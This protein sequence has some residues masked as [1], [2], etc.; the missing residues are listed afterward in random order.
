MPGSSAD[1][2]VTFCA[3]LID[4]WVGAGVGDVVVAPGSRSTP[5][6]LAALAD[7]RVRVHTHI[8]ERSAAFMALGLGRATGRPAPV[9]TTSGTAAVNLHPAVVE[10]HH[11]AVP[12]LLC[13]CDR[14][15]ELRGRSAPQTIDQ[16][17]LYGSSLRAFL[18]PGVPRDSKAGSWRSTAMEAVRRACGTVPGPVQ[19]NLA[20]AEP[21][22]GS[23]GAL[24][25]PDEEPDRVTA[26]ERLP[27]A[28][29]VSTIVSGGRGVIV[30]GAGAT[31]TASIL[32]LG[33]RLGWP[34]LA[35][36]LSGCRVDEAGVIGA[37]DLILGTP[38]VGP[39][40]RADTVLRFG[41]PPASKAL[42]QWGETAGAEVVVS[43][44]PEPSDPT[45]RATW[46]LGAPDVAATALLEAVEPGSVPAWRARW[47]RAER[48][49]QSAL[50]DAFEGQPLTEPEVA[51]MV[52]AAP[53]PD[54]ALVV[55]SSM[56]V[57]DTESFGRPRAGLTVHANRGANGIDGVTSTAVGVA[58]GGRPTFAL[59]GD[60]AFLHDTNGLLG[61]SE[62]DVDLSLVVVDNDGGGIFSFLSQARELP[63]SEF[64]RAWG[65]PHGLDLVAVARAHGTEA[66]LTATRADLGAW[67]AS[68]A[69]GPRV[70]VV[71]SD[72]A[73]NVVDH[74]R[75]QQA[76]SD[77]VRSALGL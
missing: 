25:G 5:F 75:M 19:V 20:F 70:A 37:F 45:G 2:A 51:R 36:P 15:P 57:R 7:S 69:S 28:D 44:G 59:L 4:E 40:L 71:P 60:L 50:D 34:V 31:G 77:R 66:S 14:P 32:R 67:L 24:P 1:V 65:T 13:T 11:A 42:A 56:P 29:V 48:A 3:T 30:T 54:A 43:V 39:D 76:V 46:A 64:E 53:P 16:R 27:T 62:R 41:A 68:G 58:L 63:T 12:M 73:R 10:A 61:L 33:A 74:E 23:A 47:A 6:A 52:V 55:S 9:V 8:D 22:V 21:L 72:R 38:G 18:E 26:D 35:D 17:E 49:A